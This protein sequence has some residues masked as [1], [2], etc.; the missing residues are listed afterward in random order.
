MTK[1]I[2]TGL[3]G[4]PM[5]PSRPTDPPTDYRTF[6]YPAYTDLLA[7]LLAT[8]SFSTVRLALAFVLP[9]IVV[10]GVML[11]LKF[12]QYRPDNWLLFC[13]IVLTLFSFQLL[14]ALFAQQVGL[15]AADL[16]SKTA[17]RDRNHGR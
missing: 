3:F 15:L 1:S 12:L 11:W 6:S 8:L 9:I 10:A 7:A 14:E 17:A 16:K 4:R 5:D 2:Q 13:V